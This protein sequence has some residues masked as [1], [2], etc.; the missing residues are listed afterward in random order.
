MFG[1]GWLVDP[2]C[3]V[4]DGAVVDGVVAVVVGVAVLLVD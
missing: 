4:C 1:H 2:D 3:G